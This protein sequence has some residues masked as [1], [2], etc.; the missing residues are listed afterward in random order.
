MTTEKRL[1]SPNGRG[2]HRRPKAFGDSGGSNPPTGTILA[3]VAG[4]R[5]DHK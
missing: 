4:Q 1:S 2:S 5:K 3:N